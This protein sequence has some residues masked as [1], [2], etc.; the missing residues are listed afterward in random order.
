MPTAFFLY[1]KS[2]LLLRYVLPSTIEI[3]HSLPTLGDHLRHYIKSN[4]QPII[5][6][7]HGQ[8]GTR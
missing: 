4:D 3:D 7:L 6:Y 5:M 8:D 1:K 2:L